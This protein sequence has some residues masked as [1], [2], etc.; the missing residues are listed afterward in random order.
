[1]SDFFDP[2]TPIGIVF[3]RILAAIGAAAILAIVVRLFKP[4]KWPFKNRKLKN[5]I[6]SG[7]KFRFIYNPTS[8]ASKIVTF[9]QNG[10]IGEG[11]NKNEYKWLIRRGKLDIFNIEKILYSRFSYDSKRGRLIHTNDPQCRSILGQYLEPLNEP[12]GR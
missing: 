3:L 5:I 6:L 9:S 1:M 7:R 4:L 12:R 8:G 11:Q 10:E 2:S